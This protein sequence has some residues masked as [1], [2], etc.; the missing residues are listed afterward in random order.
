MPGLLANDPPP[1]YLPPALSDYIDLNEQLGEGGFAKVILAE[2]RP[3][4]QKVAI[5]IMNKAQL[6]SMGDLHRAY[7]EIEAMKKLGTHHHIAQLYQVTETET[8]IYLVLE[9]ISGGELFDYIVA[10]ERLSEKEARS[11]FRQI[12]SA[13]IYIHSRGLAHRDLKPENMLLD[14]N[15]NIKIIDFG[16]ASD[17]NVPLVQPLVTCCGSPA[18]AA[19]ELISG[20]KYYGTGADIWSLGVVLYGLLNGFLPFDCDEDEP[21]GVLYDKIKKGQY[22]ETEFLSDGSAAV[23]RKLLEVDPVRRV[24]PRQLLNDEWIN[25]GYGSAM[26]WESQLQQETTDTKIVEELSD[27]YHMTDKEMDK[28]VKEYKYDSLT[29]HYY[30]LY[31]LRQKCPR[32]KVS[33]QTPVREPK[34]ASRTNQTPGVQ[35]RSNSVCLSVDDI[36]ITPTRRS[37]S[38]ADPADLEEAEPEKEYVSPLQGTKE[39]AASHVENLHQLLSG[40]PGRQTASNSVQ[41]RFGMAVGLVTPKFAKRIGKRVANLLT[42][43][44]S[45]DGDAPRQIKGNYKA[46]TTSTKSAKDVCSEVQRVLDM[47]SSS[48]V[49]N[50]YEICSNYVFKCRGVD[51]KRRKFA[52]QIEICLV[53]EFDNQMIGIRHARLKGD[54]WHYKNLITRLLENLQI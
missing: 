49:I 39:K 6:R 26:K 20:I 32:P 42:P 38:V 40:T 22:E 46:L 50:S 12:L 53:P 21:V 17:P 19:P 29:A 10:R 47:L 31:K 48:Q 14:C 44:K 13:V 18:Y 8:D 28:L 16:L 52:F 4:G 43:K 51:D 27:E 41:N 45:G 25:E 1:G 36:N 3:T 34:P 11:V 37:K 15:N 2:H 7:R 9:H 23:L 24:Q 33:F 54:S 35:N 5:K 30:L